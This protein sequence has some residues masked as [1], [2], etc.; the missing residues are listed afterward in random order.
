[1]SK[2]TSLPWKKW[3]HSCSVLCL[4]TEDLGLT[5]PYLHDLECKF[6]PTFSISWRPY[7]LLHH[8]GILE[9]ILVKI[10]LKRCTAFSTAFQNDTLFT[11]NIHELYVRVLLSSDSKVVGCIDQQKLNHK[12]NILWFAIYFPLFTSTD[13]YPSGK[14]QDFF[15][16]L[17]T[18]TKLQV[19]RST[20]HY[21]AKNSWVYIHVSTVTSCTFQ[22][23]IY[24]LDIK[25]IQSF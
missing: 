11:V 20:K 8:E 4:D 12:H 2:Q 5:T 7:R 16:F 1:M 21:T 14:G 25:I 19:S 22:C 10:M 9:Q 18:C 3:R 15:F 13:P 6:K 23:S 17:I 24:S